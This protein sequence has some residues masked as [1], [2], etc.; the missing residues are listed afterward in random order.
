MYRTPQLNYR[1]GN[2]FIRVVTSLLDEVCTKFD[3]SAVIDKHYDRWQQTKHPMYY[4]KSKREILEMW[5]INGEAAMEEGRLLHQAIEAYFKNEEIEYDQSRKEWKQ[6]LAFLEEYYLTAYRT[7]KN[8]LSSEHKL[9]GKVDLIVQNEDG[10]YT[11]YDWKRSKHGILQ[12]SNYDRNCKQLNLYREIFETEYGI[13]VRSMFIVRFH[14]SAPNYE[15]V[16]VERM[17][18]ETIAM[19]EQPQDLVQSITFVPLCI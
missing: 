7:E 3:R 17:E 8:L 10:T 12:D 2:Q 1:Y 6:F 19:L 16:E 11:M 14:P 15:V 4:K 5:R 9:A 13:K 18:A